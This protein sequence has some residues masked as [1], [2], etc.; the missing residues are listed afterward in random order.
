MGYEGSPVKAPPNTRRR[1]MPPTPQQ[2]SFSSTDESQWSADLEEQPS[3]WSTRE[4][5][6]I[7]AME[8][9]LDKSDE[10]KV[11]KK[12][13][14][15]LVDQEDS[16]VCLRKIPAHARRRGSR[17]FEIFST[18]EKA[19]HSVASRNCWLEHPG[20]RVVLQE[21]WQ[22]DW[23]DVNYERTVAK[24]PPCPERR[25]RTTLPQQ[26][27][28]LTREEE[29]QWSAQERTAMARMEQSVNN[30]EC[31]K[32]DIEE[33]EECS[34]EPEYADIDVKQILRKATR[35]GRNILLS[36][37]GERRRRASGRK[38]MAMG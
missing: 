18:K 26:S 7:A 1:I 12:T 22:S 21:R 2:I 17:M 13:L 15:L 20:K 30:S 34:L 27:S 14:G 9:Y 19:D 32:L 11:E 33:V 37:Q 29:S 35:E 24:A 3:I 10:V 6:V 36:V 5:R 8:N 23:Q 16:K 31:K 38:Q 28:S 4:R 25:M